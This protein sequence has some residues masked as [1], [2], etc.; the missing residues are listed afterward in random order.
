MPDK[1]NYVSAY[2]GAQASLINN[3]LSFD[4]KL[5]SLP[6]NQLKNETAI[7]FQMRP[8]EYSDL[9]DG[10]ILPIFHQDKVAFLC[11]KEATVLV[12]NS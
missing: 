3:I 9:I 2:H 11:Y 1:L 5:P 8:I 12:I 4:K 7:S 10:N 6:I